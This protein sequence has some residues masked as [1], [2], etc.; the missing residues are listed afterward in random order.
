VFSLAGGL[1]GALA[2]GLSFGL[3]GGFGGGLVERLAG[4][5]FGAG[6]GILLVAAAGFVTGN[7]VSRD[8][9]PARG[10]RWNHRGKS[11]VG[12]L[13]VGVAGGLAG[14]PAVGL[15]SS[16]AVLLALGVEAIPDDISA[17]ASPDALLLRDRR[18]AIARTVAI[19]LAIGLAGML[20]A[21]VKIGIAF[22]FR[23]GVV[24]AAGLVGGLAIT[25]VTSAWP[26]WV[27]ARTW[28]AI[29][30][31]LPWHV[32]TFLADAHR[33]GILRQS[34]SVYQFRHLELQ[35]HLASHPGAEISPP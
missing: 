1:A 25:A 26:S 16:L 31:Q 5:E 3:A 21:G 20:A 19:G 23:A 6:L 13:A 10:A 24:A 4:R 35:Q 11:L 9:H 27:I 34:G 32:M 18:A 28:L 12:G 7:I 8:H 29:R 14:G 33:R 15:A 2:G 22:G 30:G 17:A